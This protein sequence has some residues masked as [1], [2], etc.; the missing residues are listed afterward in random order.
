MGM[1]LGGT[2]LKHGLVS[3]DG[4]LHELHTM[5]SRATEGAAAVLAQLAAAI[6][7]LKTEAHGNALPLVAVGIGCPGTIN[8]AT[9]TLIGALPNIPGLRGMPIV[10]LVEEYAG[11]PGAGDNDANAMAFAE[12][13]VG[14]GRGFTS[15]FGA[16][17]GTGIGGGMIIGGEVYRG[18]GAAGEIGH[19]RIVPEGRP[20]PCGGAG[21]LEQYASGPALS[22]L[23]QERTDQFLDAGV[24]LQ[25]WSQG[26]PAARETVNEWA[27]WLARGLGCALTLLHPQ[28]LVVGGGIMAA[29]DSLADL[30]EH[31]IRHSCLDLVAE[32]VVIRR[33]ELGPGAGVIGAALLSLRRYPRA[34]GVCA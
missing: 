2:S 10:A 34:S 33:A 29:G 13:E 30:L 32:T 31:K 15:V 22:R 8:E 21:C 12:A 20:C 24:V 18:G 23:F 28:C 16:T 7:A 3:D 17:I 26:D 11:L 27:R 9:G 6:R 4:V 1:D 25:R 14:A 5:P 19:I